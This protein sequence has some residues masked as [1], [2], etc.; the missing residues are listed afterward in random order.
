MSHP[1]PQLR[2]RAL[3]CQRGDALLFSGISFEL[4]PE[5][6]LQVGGANGSGKTS[7]L[8]ILAGLSRPVEGEVFWCGE[9]ISHQRARYAAEMAYLGH[10]LGLKGE[11]TVMENLKLGMAVYGK[12]QTDEQT[13]SHLEQ[14]GIR[15]KEDL[16]IRTLSAG[17]RQRVALA[18]LL[19]AEARLW[20]LDEPFTAL[21]AHGVGLVQDLLNQHARH[22][23]MAVITSHQPVT[24]ER[25]LRSLSLA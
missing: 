22:G 13:K 25:A 5:Q 2:A 4:A 7:L 16:P 23:G 12:P 18:R 1:S 19:C 8:R 17:Q 21:D 9:D 20:I 24:L 3:E 14:V 15:H 10:H 6:V 11:L